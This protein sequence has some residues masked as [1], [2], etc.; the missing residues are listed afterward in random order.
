MHKLHVDSKQI[1]KSLSLSSL[2][3]IYGN[4]RMSAYS[5]NGLDMQEPSFRE[6]ADSECPDLPS[7]SAQSDED[8]HCPQ[9]KIIWYY[10]MYRWRAKARMET[11]RV[12]GNVR[13]A[14]AQIRLRIRAV[15]SGPSLSANR[16]IR[17]QRMYRWRAKARMILC[18]CAGWS[19]YAHFAYDRRFFFTWQGPNIIISCARHSIKVTWHIWKSYRHSLQ[20]ITKTR[21]F[22]YIENFTTKKWKLSDEK[23]W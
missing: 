22:K 16:I 19:E 10:R 17:Y 5:L 9:N 15:W 12:L 21:Q 8:L 13:T 7:A 1:N 4:K 3:E 11:L 6:S 18:A 2:S 14:N 23:F 20:G